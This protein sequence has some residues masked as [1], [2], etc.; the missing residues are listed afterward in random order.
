MTRVLVERDAASD[1]GAL[2]AAWAAEE[3]FA[4]LPRR[5]VLGEAD[6]AAILDG[7][8]AQLR[9]GHFGILTSGSTGAPKL[10]IGA[11]E[12]ATALARALH[13]AQGNQTCAETIL[14]LPLS[15]SFAF[16][17]QWVWATEHDRALVPT[18]GLADPRSLRAALERTDD[19][20]L[21]LVG[22]QGGLLAGAFD[23]SS[24]D[25]VT[26]LHFAGGRFPQGSL[27]ALRR[28]FPRAAITN[29]YGCAEAMPRLTLRPAE[30]SDDASDI[31][32]P[33]PGIELR[34]DA[35]DR[36]LFRSPYGAVAV[37]EA[38]T[39][40]PIA[41]DAWVPTGDL[42]APHASGWRLLGRA[43]E[44]FK[45]HGEKVSLPAVLDTVGGAWDGETGVYRT[46]DRG[47]EDGYVLVLA[48]AAETADVRGI[49]R[50]LRAHHARAQWPLRIETTSK[51]P[52]LDN[53]KVDN[54]ALGRPQ[55]RA[56]AWA[57]RI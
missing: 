31:G 44:V 2:R 16:V 21:C 14:A 9:I 34:A 30:A 26:R 25:G 17:N 13:A 52:R 28:V 47:G 10:V 20:M 29:N 42:G 36:L 55:D 22:V 19:A 54:A 11:R 5:S 35:E 1:L 51:L 15:Y 50:A 32:A 18:D 6:V 53:G 45:R 43:S 49:L 33:L 48:P 56:V 3:T 12:R 57:Q 8:P 7:L 27:P 24:F 38:D 23:G 46:T 41:G 37:H 4:Y 39:L 40:Q